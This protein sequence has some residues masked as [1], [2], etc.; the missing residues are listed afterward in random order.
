MRPFLD[1]DVLVY[2]VS[3]DP[4]RARATRLIAEGGIVNLQV[5]NEFVEVGRRKLGLSAHDVREALADVL[6]YLDPPR[7]LDLATHDA[8]L[9]LAEAGGLSWWDALIVAAALE[10]GCDTL[11]TDDLQD[12]RRFDR[13]LIRNPFE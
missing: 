12:G 8:A 6:F 10:A 4:R 9:C 7:P 13:L 3:K 1:T 2:A 11:W 5:M